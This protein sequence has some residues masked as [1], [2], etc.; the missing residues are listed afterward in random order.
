MIAQHILH[1]TPS[2]YGYWNLL[3]LAGTLLSGLTAPRILHSFNPNKII[4]ISTS[5]IFVGAIMLYIGITLNAGALIFFLICSILYYF[6]GLLFPCATLYASSAI[7]DKPSASS[8]M[9]FINMGS[10]ML[11]VII[12]GYLPGSSA[13]Q[14]SIILIAFI[15]I[16]IISWVLMK[17][18]N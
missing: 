11:A 9:S 4:A 6:S 5:I 16:N 2:E 8:M 10:A 13:L 14:F 12:M 18:N 3:A 15:A 17:R 7:D 1:L